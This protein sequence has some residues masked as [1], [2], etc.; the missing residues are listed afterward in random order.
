MI[1]ITH[2]FLIL[3]F[4]AALSSGCSSDPISNSPTEQPTPKGD[5]FTGPSRQFSMEMNGVSLIDTS[6]T[7]PEGFR[8]FANR[9]N[10][11]NAFVLD[12]LVSS[13]DQSKVT[14]LFFRANLPFVLGP[15]RYVVSEDLVSAGVLNKGEGYT[16]DA[17]WFEVTHYDSTFHTMSGVFNLIS[18]GTEDTLRGSFSNI[19]FSGGLADFGQAVAMIDDKQFD[20][21]NDMSIGSPGSYWALAAVSVSSSAWSSTVSKS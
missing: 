8:V 11:D 3:I 9:T 1:R 19:G 6:L 4:A 5:G 18:R 2:Y 16:L 13:S 7:F 14:A 20:A 15:K 17:G 10:Y 21:H 12:Y